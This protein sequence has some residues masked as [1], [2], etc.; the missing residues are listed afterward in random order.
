MGE[1]KLRPVL[2]APREDKINRYATTPAR[3]Y[4]DGLHDFR[5]L[6]PL[7]GRMAIYLGGSW[8]GRGSFQEKRTIG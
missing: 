3:S 6:W 5:I 7:V 8:P 4:R 1:Y 2:T